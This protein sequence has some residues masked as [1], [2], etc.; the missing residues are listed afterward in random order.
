MDYETIILQKEDGVATIILN[1]PDKLNAWSEQLMNEFI[2][3]VDDISQDNTVRSVILTGTGR[4]F[5]A[6][7]DL[8]LPVFEIKGYSVEVRN[9]FQQVNRMTLCLRNLNKPVI[10]AVNGPAMGARCSLIMACDIIIASETAIFSLA[11]VNIGY[12]P[13]AGATYLL[14]RLV[15]V[16]RACELIFTG[17]TIDAA[18][19]ER[20]GLVN[21]VVAPDALL[22]T[23]KELALRI[24][25]GPPVAISLAKGCIYQG[26]HMT[27]EQALSH[28]A[29]A[30]CLTLQTED[31][32]E[33]IQAFK[34]KR[35]PVY[36]GK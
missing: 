1:R 32:K 30:A 11:F 17:K 9:F 36:K 18:E 15:G 4:A 25:S 13:D 12:H 23:V 24:A 6:G 5:C 34:E 28:E 2:K 26:L 10:A 20:I 29:E 21:Q 8:A 33:G 3:A 16:S 22:S 14:P 35:K 27:F 19:A 7:G 31:Q